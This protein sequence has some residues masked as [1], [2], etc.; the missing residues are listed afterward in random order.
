MTLIYRIGSL[1][2]IPQLLGLSWAAYAP[3][4][5]LG[6]PFPAATATK[7][8]VET[9]LRENLVLIAEKDG[10]MAATVSLQFPWNHPYLPYHY[11]YYWWLAVH[12]DFKRQGIA[13]QLLDHL[14]TVIVR[15]KLHAPALLLS[16]SRYHPWLIDFYLKRGYQ[17]IGTLRYGKNASGIFLRKVLIPELLRED[18]EQVIEIDIREKIK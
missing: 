4:R 10:K 12:P 13:T 18:R 15:D 17:N 11:P 9:N 3:I 8:L 14:E 6:L 7:A 2:D 5:E 1:S 16:T